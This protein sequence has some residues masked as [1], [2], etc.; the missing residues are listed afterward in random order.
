MQENTNQNFHCD[1]LVEK[2]IEM[3]LHKFKLDPKYEI[4]MNKLKI[5][6]ESLEAIIKDPENTIYEEISELKRQVDLDR[7]NLKN[8][9]DSKADDL[10]QQLETY[11]KRFKAEYQ[12]NIDLEKYNQ[13]V[14]SSRKKL[15]EF[16]NCLNLFSVDN[17]EREEKTT[18]IEE[19]I[20]ILQP[21]I[22]DIKNELFSNLSIS[23]KPMGT[24]LNGL[25]GKLIVEVKI[26]YILLMIQL[27]Q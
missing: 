9:I 3:E 12:T 15:I 11:E 10:I 26:N 24:N 25:F 13:L 19:T 20:T 7:E 16:E 6:I 23:Y 4:T 18:E 22:M 8:E 21:N 14:K 27:I 17:K 1:E 2:L 5:E